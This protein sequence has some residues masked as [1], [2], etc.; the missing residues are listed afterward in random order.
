M[1]GRATAYHT[2]RGFRYTVDASRPGRAAIASEAGS[3]HRLGYLFTHTGIV[4]ICVGGRID[5]ICRESNAARR[6]A[7]AETRDIPQSR[8]P[9]QSRLSPRN[10]SFR[11]HHGARRRRAD[12]LFLN[13]GDGYYVQDL[14]FT[15]ALKKF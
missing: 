12:V 3:Y 2:Q 9:P 6:H 15:V 14:P 1:I 13:V 4:V 5:G 11:E 8:V 10:P 7:R